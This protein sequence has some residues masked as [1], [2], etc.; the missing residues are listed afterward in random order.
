MASVHEL[1]YR[2]L[3]LCFR[4]SYHI[5]AKMFFAFWAVTWVYSMINF[6]VLDVITGF[7]PMAFV[8]FLFLSWVIFNVAA[9]LGPPEILNNW[10]RINFFFPSLHWYRTFITII[11]EGAYNNLHYTL[12]VLAVWLVLMKCTSPLATRNRVRKAQEVFRWYNERD[13]I[14]G[15]H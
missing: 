3:D 8:P 10:Y 14:G 5:D 2:G 12:P 4:G 6:D 11:T 1:V 9:S 15:P 7:I 13:A